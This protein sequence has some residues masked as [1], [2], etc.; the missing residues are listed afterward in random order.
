MWI[1]RE[2]EGE[3]TASKKQTIKTTT[4]TQE[5]VLYSKVCMFTSIV[6]ERERES[7]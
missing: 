1:E 2:R 6:R 4:T 5:P 3:R 7:F